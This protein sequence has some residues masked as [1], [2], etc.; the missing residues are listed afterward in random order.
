[1]APDQIQYQYSAMGK[2]SLIGS[3][4]VYFNL[5]HSHEIALAAIA[6]HEEIGV[7]VEY[8]RPIEEIDQLA[9]TCFSPREYLEFTQTPA[10]A[11]R[12][13]FFNGWTR[14]EAYIKAIGA[15]LSYPLDQFD[16]SLLPWQSPKLTSIA[17]H[18]DEVDQ[19]MLQDIP[20]GDDYA[21]CVALKARHV[22]VRFWSFFKQ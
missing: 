6:A 10:S 18:P 21:A 3:S 4:G 9:R 2:P 14:K 5:A 20:L 17:G 13:A 11:S 22:N 8:I 12:R 19:W 16:V 15:G 1:M 7:D